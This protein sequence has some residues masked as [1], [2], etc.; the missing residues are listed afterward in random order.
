MISVIV[1][2]IDPEKRRSLANNIAHTIGIEHEIIAFDNT[3][4]KYGLTKVYNICA[5]QSKFDYLCFAHED[6]LFYSQNW[7]KIIL[8][9]LQE[10]NCG[11][12]GFAGS[13]IK[14]KAI[15]GWAQQGAYNRTNYIQRFRKKKE[16]RIFLNNIPEGIDFLEVV[17]LDGMCLFAH[18][19][20]WQENPFDEKTLEGF[21]GYDL[22][23][24]LG[25]IEKNYHNYLCNCI[26]LEHFSVGSYN[27]EWV[28]CM[29]QLHQ[30]RWK[31]KLPICTGTFAEQEIKKN[32]DFTHYLFTKYTIKSDSSFAEAFHALCEYSKTGTPSFLITLLLKFLIHRILPL[33]RILNGKK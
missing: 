23:F 32:E 18:K 10:P 20:L 33:K 30:S 22:D 28:R 16:A 27:K 13:L 14:S 7:G 5:R 26:L 19:Q 9:K 3:V 21:H 6:I 4:Y 1:C 31:D 15:S 8:G 29:K 12:I 25:A 2:S 24:C 11:V 17:A